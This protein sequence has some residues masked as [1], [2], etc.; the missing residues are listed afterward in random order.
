MSPMSTSDGDYVTFTIPVSSHEHLGRTNA[1]SKSNN[2]YVS[3]AW[4]KFS[5]VMGFKG[6]VSRA[7]TYPV[8]V[9][10][11]LHVFYAKEALVRPADCFA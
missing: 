2:K 9:C 11:H 4:L 10:P 1:Q 6:S 5:M 7:L 8:L 3:P